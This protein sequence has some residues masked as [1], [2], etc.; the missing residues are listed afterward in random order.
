M[1]YRCFAVSTSEACPA[2]AKRIRC[3]SEHDGCNEHDNNPCSDKWVLSY[4]LPKSFSHR[5]SSP[6]RLC[7]LS[8]SDRRY[9]RVR[10]GWTNGLWVELIFAEAMDV[11]VGV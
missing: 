3:E 6:L 8:I 11:K 4:F 2:P 5:L 7:C 1:C 9:G 10:K